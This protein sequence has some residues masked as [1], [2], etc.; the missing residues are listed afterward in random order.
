MARLHLS[1]AGGREASGAR[2]MMNR[3]IVARGV[4]VRY[5]RP[6]DTE[7]RKKRESLSGS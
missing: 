1:L 5:R 2:A 3:Q 4:S 7:A 6:D